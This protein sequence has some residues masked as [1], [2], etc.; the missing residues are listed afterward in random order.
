MLVLK[1]IKDNELEYNNELD[2]SISSF[3][4]ESDR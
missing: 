2:T 3:L 4:L 1:K